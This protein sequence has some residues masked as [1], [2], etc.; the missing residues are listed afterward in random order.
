MPDAKKR[1]EPELKESKTHGG[2]LQSG[3]GTDGRQCFAT[4]AQA[5]N[6]Q[7]I[8]C[9][10]GG[11]MPFNRKFKVVDRHA[12]TV[13]GDPHQRLAAGGSRDFNAC[14]TRVDRIFN[15]FLDDARRPLDHLTGRNTVDHRLLQPLHV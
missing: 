15:E 6:I 9:E 3:N 14:G 7:K 1:V 4:K 13:V 11:A 2:D 12:R 10:F 8:I 5:A